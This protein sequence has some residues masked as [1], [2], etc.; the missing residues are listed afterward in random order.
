MVDGR[1]KHGRLPPPAPNA[2][3]MLAPAL[4]ETPT[5]DFQVAPAR[6]PAKVSEDCG[7]LHPNDVTA[8]DRLAIRTEERDLQMHIL[9]VAQRR[10]TV[11][12]G[13]LAIPEDPLVDDAHSQTSHGLPGSDV[14]SCFMVDRTGSHTVGRSLVIWVVLSQPDSSLES[15]TSTDVD[16]PH[17]TSTLLARNEAGNRFD[18][19]KMLRTPI[20]PN[21]IL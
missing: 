16:G 1:G 4:H 7:L 5:L 15:K 9:K 17:F 11:Q 21:A 8:A 2:P 14:T 6:I 3:R 18:T 13:N 19:E 20:D 10:P 12:V